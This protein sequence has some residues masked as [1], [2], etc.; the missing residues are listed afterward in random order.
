MK[1]RFALNLCM[2]FFLATG[3]LPR[4]AAQTD[5]P[6]DKLKAK[7]TKALQT[8][9]NDLEAGNDRESADIAGSILA[10]LDQPGGLTPSALAANGDRMRQLARDLIRRNK[11]ESA[12]A[13]NLAACS[14]LKPPGDG[15]DG[16][17][18]SNPKSGGVPGPGGL[19][20][21]LPFD[22]SA[23]GGIV[24]DESGAGNDGRVSG[25]TWVPDGRFGGAYRFSLSSMD[26]RIVIPDNPSLNPGKL[27]VA[28]WIKSSL[29]NGFWSRIADKDYRRNY[30]LA[31]CGDYNGKGLRGKL[32]FEHNGSFIASARRINDGQ[33]HHVAATYDGQTDIL[34]VD[35]AEAA[36]KPSRK[37][38]PLPGSRWDL[39]IG[40]SAV[41]YGTG[42]ILGFDG[43]IDEVRIYNRALAAEEVKALAT[44]EQ[45]GINTVNTPAGTAAPRTSTPVNEGSTHAEKLKTLKQAFEQ[46]LISKEIY[47]QKV[48]EIL[49]GI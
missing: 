28:A 32:D 42:E 4:L 16:S 49:D 31:L 40:N 35:G 26:D 12:A 14:T 2:A 48:K 22:K 29:D 27:T 11:L 18:P 19:V 47:D 20:L 8:A 36:K 3:F 15:S 39:C 10:S 7:W 46:G 30:T 44:A 9:K 5:S 43:L 1:I 37:N 17:V 24:R 34:Y 25:A 33:W 45:P 41:D 38:G 13:V 21:Y 6:E 23:Q